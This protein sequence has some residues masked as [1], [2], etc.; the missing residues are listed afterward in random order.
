MPP[1]TMHRIRRRLA[2]RARTAH[3]VM[4]II[5]SIFLGPRAHFLDMDAFFV[6]YISL[7]RRLMAQKERVAHGVRRITFFESVMRFYNETRKCISLY[8]LS[9]RQVKEKEKS[10]AHVNFDRPTCILIID[11]RRGR[12]KFIDCK[13]VKKQ[14]SRC[15]SKLNEVAAKIFVNSI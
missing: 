9:A 7:E 2:Q 6:M 12:R 4:D 5:C 15:N 1:T 13:E 11:L 8:I 10:D 14:A 3:P